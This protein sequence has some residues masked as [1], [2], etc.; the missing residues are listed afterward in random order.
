MSNQGQGKASGTLTYSLAEIQQIL[1]REDVASAVLCGAHWCSFRGDQEMDRLDEFVEPNSDEEI[2]I[3]ERIKA[4]YSLAEMA[5]EAAGG[6][7]VEL[8]PEQW[9]AYVD[10]IEEQSEECIIK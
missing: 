5:K 8:T 7:P 2:R 10:L 9:E 3:H 1:G 4:Y 6:K